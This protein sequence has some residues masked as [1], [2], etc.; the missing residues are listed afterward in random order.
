MDSNVQQLDTGAASTRGVVRGGERLKEHRD[1][2]M[3]ATKKTGCY[4]GLEK[5]ELRESEPILYNK[6]F[7]RLRAGVVDARET[8][9]KIAA[10]PPRR[11][12]SRRASCASPCI[13]RPAT[14]FS[15]RP[16]SSSTSAPW[17]RQSNI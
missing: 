1:R 16:A 3:A 8:S 7:S 10:S 12:S 11:S 14:A 4:A 6:L 2:L 9:K 13:T 5:L 17:V 15:H